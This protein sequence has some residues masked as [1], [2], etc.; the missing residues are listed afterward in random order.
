VL[1]GLGPGVDH[2][3]WCGPL[4]GGADVRKVRAWVMGA[5]LP[6]GWAHDRH[7]WPTADDTHLRFRR[8]DGRPVEVSL[9]SAWFGA[10]D[11]TPAAAEAAYGELGRALALRC[12][13]A[14]ILSS[15]VAT[16]RA[17]M[18]RMI[19]PPREPWPEWARELVA[20]SSGQHRMEWLATDRELAQVVELDGRLM[21]GALCWGLGG[22]GLVH[23]QGAGADKGS[24]GWYRVRFFVPRA[25]D[26]PYGLL[27]VKDDAGGWW[28]PAEPSSSFETWCGGP[29]I[30]VARDAG[31]S[32]TVCE[33]LLAADPAAQPLDR[34]ARE[35][36]GMRQTFELA[37]DELAAAGARAVLLHGIGGLLSRRAWVHRALPAA[38]AHRIP[39]GA[40]GVERAGEWVGWMESV[41]PDRGDLAHPEWA[42]QIYS[43]ARARLLSGPGATGVLHLPCDSV[44]GFRGDA[45][46][47]TADP[48]W[49]DDGKPG[50][51]RV[52]T[53]VP[54]P[55]R[56]ANLAGFDRARSKAAR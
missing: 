49:P 15:P 2:A 8:P 50:R 48:G 3:Y 54:G 5:T 19:E 29:E 51:F 17:A 37:G 43:R 1:G 14:P 47:L 25:W 41:E 7:Y 11:Y 21:Y 46:Y 23:D 39:E 56:V 16:A 30:M 55:V 35:L 40:R 34:W 4:P 32:V 10:G 12:R 42:A 44:A 45:L 24:R 33:R 22:G 26:R 27:P 38:D 36:V 28:W 6:D 52:K 31:W 13:G 53:T 9:A 20:G 18:D